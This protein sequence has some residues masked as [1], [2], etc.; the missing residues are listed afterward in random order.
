M[1]NKII[2]IK[3][4]LKIDL[5]I[6]EYQRPYKWTLNNVNQLIDDILTFKDK[7]AYRLETI[8]IYKDK[9]IFYS[10]NFNNE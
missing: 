6:P 10:I 3:D 5:K 7:K 8:V 2:T 4:I 1:D 9:I